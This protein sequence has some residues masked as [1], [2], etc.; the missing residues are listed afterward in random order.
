MKIFKNQAKP[1]GSALTNVWFLARSFLGW[2]IGRKGHA[3]YPKNKI[4]Q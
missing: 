1:S 4:F 2:K 3:E